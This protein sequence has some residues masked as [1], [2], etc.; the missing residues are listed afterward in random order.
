MQLFKTPPML[1]AYPS[2]VAKQTQNPSLHHEFHAYSSTCVK[3][4]GAFYLKL[5][6]SVFPPMTAVFG[7]P[8]LQSPQKIFGEAPAHLPLRYSTVQ[9]FSKDENYK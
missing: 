8:A 3:S 9:L 2:K 1:C 5:T 4:A 7:L 6:F